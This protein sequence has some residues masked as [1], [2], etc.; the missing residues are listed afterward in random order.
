[1]KNRHQHFDPIQHMR[2]G[3]EVRSSGEKNSNSQQ[4]RETII[5]N[6]GYEVFLR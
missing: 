5:Y 4:G 3:G 1:M 6:I 2:D